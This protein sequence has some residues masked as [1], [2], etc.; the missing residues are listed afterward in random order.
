MKVLVLAGSPKGEKSVT[1][2]YVRY[3]EKRYPEDLFA[4]RHIVPEAKALE[5]DPRGFAALEEGMAQAD[6][7]LWA[8]PV[9]FCCVHSRYKRFIELLFDRHAETCIKGRAAAVLTTSIHLHDDNAV[10]YMRG[11]IE[12]LGL[13]FVDSHTPAMRD[14][15]KPKGQK[16]LEQFYEN[17]RQAVATGDHLSPTCGPRTVPSQPFAPVDLGTALHHKGTILVLTD[18]LEGN[19]GALVGSFSSAFSQ[20]P[21][22]YTLADL[23]ML[24]PCMGCLHCGPSNRCTYE[25][26]DRY[27]D[28]F[29]NKIAQADTIVLAGT[30]K[31]RFISSDW[32]QFFDRSFFLT[33]HQNL[34][35][36]KRFAFILSGNYSRMPALQSFIATYTEQWQCHL[37][38]IVTDESGD[39]MQISKELLA[40]ARTLTRQLSSGYRRP[41]SY[42]GVGG[43]RLFRDEI[44]G[45]L[46]IV[47]KADHRIY[48]RQGVYD[49]PNRNIPKR[50]LVFLADWITRIPPIQRQFTARMVDGMIQP[51]RKILNRTCPKG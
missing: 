6:L 30:L 46:R 41:A 50:I 39:S 13:H 11:V 9:Y 25:G 42:A 20:P 40:L 31:D 21:E 48:R 19:T 7:I 1:M 5:A 43:L 36:G 3:L 35:W 17:T 2:Q 22:V 32:R 18:T 45:D 47:F 15:L 38:G 28:F 8:F 24:G 34:L 27:T 12:D 23:G 4:V 26:K 10:T 33:H 44:Y 51:Y 14:L 49:F 16:A 37:G 29:R